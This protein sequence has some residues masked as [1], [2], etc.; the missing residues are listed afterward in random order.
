MKNS[1]TTR[2]EYK[3]YH[4]AQQE[5]HEERNSTYNPQPVGIAPPPHHGRRTAATYTKRTNSEDG[6]SAPVSG[7]AAS[8]P[9]VSG[10][11]IES[12]LPSTPRRASADGFSPRPRSKL[13]SASARL[14]SR[15]GRRV[16]SRVQLPVAVSRT[17]SWLES[18]CRCAAV[19]RCTYFA[20]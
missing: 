18:I 17:I 3:V 4:R 1:S 11:S 2:Y 9:V 7:Q 12:R 8:P 14:R 6:L 16:A 5:H 19:P 20:Q 10:A 13:G 15:S